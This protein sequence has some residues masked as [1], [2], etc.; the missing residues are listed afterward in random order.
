ME[1]V[2]EAETIAAYAAIVWCIQE[3]NQ[4]FRAEIFAP[5]RSDLATA[6]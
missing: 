2:A 1:S 3:V 5:R 4:T 6:R